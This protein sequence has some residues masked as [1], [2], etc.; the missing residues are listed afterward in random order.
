[1]WVVFIQICH[2]VECNMHI[3]CTLET[4]IALY[5]AE[6]DLLYSMTLRY[7]LITIPFKSTSGILPPRPSCIQDDV[8]QT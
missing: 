1:M 5:G 8:P 7:M 4:D 6:G 3:Y 2:L